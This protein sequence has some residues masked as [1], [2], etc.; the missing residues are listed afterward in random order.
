MSSD[1]EDDDEVSESQ[2]SSKR[3]DDG[4]AAARF[5]MAVS[6]VKTLPDATNSAPG[7][8]G[9]IQLHNDEKLKVLPTLRFSKDFQSR[10]FAAANMYG[11][12]KQAMEGDVKASRP[13]FYDYVAR[14]KWDAWNS[15]KGMSSADA[16]NA[17]TDSFVEAPKLPS[18]LSSPTGRRWSGDPPVERVHG[19]GSLLAPHSP[20]SVATDNDAYLSSEE[21]N[22]A[23][24]AREAAEEA[25]RSSSL[26]EA[27]GA[28]YM[29]PASFRAE[30]SDGSSPPKR[31]NAAAAT[32][33]PLSAY[34]YA[35]APTP[36]YNGA[37]GVAV[38]PADSER[39]LPVQIPYTVSHTQPEQLK[40][41][42]YQAPTP[43]NSV[44]LPSTAPAS[45][46]GPRKS[47]GLLMKEA[48][49]AL[50]ALQTEVCCFRESRC[51]EV[52]A[53]NERI[54][55]MKREFD[56]REIKKKKSKSVLLWLLK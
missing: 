49:T 42:R 13:A 35:S 41:V 50:Q 37:T 46:F 12:Y 19:E 10:L 54:E 15:R 16:K 31:I 32:A 48:E 8:V 14:A 25:E 23:L 6:L 51:T 45:S 18:K 1:R 4:H 34:P 28:V 2:T 24:A 30:R 55:M 53:L 9:N 38:Y 20:L 40:S 47:D 7:G 17:Y 29:T 43:S 3:G 39:Q 26:S 56:Q 27:A 21:Y 22:A 5:Q 11:L 36:G 52:A 44:V 33:P